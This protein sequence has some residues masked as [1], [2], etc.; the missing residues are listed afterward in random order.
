MWKLVSSR[1]GKIIIDDFKVQNTR[2]A[3]MSLSNLKLKIE[4]WK[5]EIF[6]T[7]GKVVGTKRTWD[8]KWGNWDCHGMSNSWRIRSTEETIR[9]GQQ[10]LQEKIWRKFPSSSIQHFL[11][12][13]HERG[14]GERG[15]GRIDGGERGVRGEKGRRW[16][17]DRQSPIPFPSHWK[18][19][20]DH[21]VQCCDL[22]CFQCV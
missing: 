17:K 3:K 15:R 10:D 9:K 22:M 14:G 21:I 2:S 11:T 13:F 20:V 8:T 4:E 18:W 5:S 1:G 16:G 12:L 7:P 6:R 19:T